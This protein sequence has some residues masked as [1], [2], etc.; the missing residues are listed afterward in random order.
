[1]ERRLKKERNKLY[2]R[3]TLIMLTV[4]LTVSIVFCTIFL[5]V[6]KYKIQN[7]EL[8]NISTFTKFLS[9]VYNEMNHLDV[10]KSFLEKYDLVYDEQNEENNYKTQLIISDKKANKV[11]VDTTKT[12]GVRFLLKG[13][14][15]YSPEA[16]G[17][18]NYDSIRDKLNE[19]QYKYINKLLSTTRNDGNYYELICTKLQFRGLYIIPLEL[20]LVLVDGKD[21]RFVIDDNVETFDLSEN[22]IKKAAVFDSSKVA[23]NK[24]PNSFI[25]KKEFNNDYISSLNNEQKKQHAV[26]VSTGF[27]EYIVYVSNYQDFENDSEYEKENILLFQY[28]KRINLFDYCKNELIINVAIIFLF[29]LTIAVILCVMIWRTVKTQIIE[30]HKRIEFTNAL[31]HDIKTPLFVISGY[32]YSLKEDIDSGERDIY[33]DKILDQSDSINSLVH[34][35]LDLSKLDSYSVKLNLSEFDLSELVSD[36]TKNYIK[37]PDN[38]TIKVSVS[39]NNTIK[40]DKELVRQA[41]ENL[42]DNA[43][44]YSLPDSEIAIEVEAKSLSVSNRCDNLTKADL[45]NLTQPY[46]RKDKS[47]NRKGNG[48]GLSIVKS[49]ADL[50]NTKLIIKLKNDIISFKISF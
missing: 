25:L 42:I 6:K 43:L 3:I 27:L 38:K 35:M 44:I 31:A 16:Y 29:F 20:K 47:R 22:I 9:L 5:N 48:L 7:E 18:I 1:M 19:K 46:Y 39:G 12:V 11:V 33:I 15:D 37:L 32:A 36:I 4:W 13:T 10:D 45:K 17:L 21:K 34:N 8:M 28:A 2:L 50:H 30:E 26:M 49:I 40:A 23:R 41:V 24:I 14:D